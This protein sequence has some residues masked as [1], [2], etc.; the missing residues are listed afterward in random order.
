MGIGLQYYRKE[1]K[2]YRVKITLNALN[3]QQKEMLEKMFETSLENVYYLGSSYENNRDNVA[4][5]VQEIISD[6][7]PIIEETIPYV[8]YR[9]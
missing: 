5:K 8:D 9:F 7:K 3:D 4:L 1:A 2:E 6:L